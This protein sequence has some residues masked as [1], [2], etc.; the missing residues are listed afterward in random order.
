M[1][2]RRSTVRSR[3]AP[4]FLLI[5]N[6]LVDCHLKTFLNIIK[7]R[8]LL[9][10]INKIFSCRSINLIS[11]FILLITATPF[12]SF[13]QS[14]EKNKIPF[15]K[16]G[17]L[18]FIKQNSRHAFKI[19]AIEIA[20]NSQERA[21]GLM[22]HR[23]LS[24]SQGMLFIYPKEKVLSFWMKN[25]AIPLDIIFI[26]KSRR[27][28]KVHSNAVPMDKTSILSG[29]PVLYALE[30]NAGFC[31]RYAIADGDEIKFEKFPR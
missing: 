11:I 2:F 23:S 28:I 25:T 27:I 1:A 12:S 24:D 17:R 29:E 14:I 13:A 7:M 16:D 10:W 8:N 3:S 19:I 22:G 4:N 9:L 6:I 18:S 30:V 5:V 20:D 21:R 31:A 15:T 26:N